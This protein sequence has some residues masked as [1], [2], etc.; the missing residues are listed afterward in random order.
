MKTF[1]SAML[2]AALSFPLTSYGQ[3]QAIP[4]HVDR[5]AAI[6]G[7]TQN[8]SFGMLPV[9]AGN[10]GFYTRLVSSQ[11]VE[12]QVRWISRDGKNSAIF[13]L[14]R[15]PLDAPQTDF[16]VVDFTP[17]PDGGMA[18]LVSL[19]R[20]RVSELFRIIEFNA[21][22][23]YRR[24][25]APRQLS[26]SP[27]RIAA[28]S[29]GDFFLSGGTRDHFGWGSMSQAIVDDSGNI[30]K[31]IDLRLATPTSDAW[32]GPMPIVKAQDS[33]QRE[34]D[35]R[36]AAASSPQAKLFQAA[37]RSAA[38][39]GDDGYVYFTWPIS[40][41]LVY[42]ISDRGNVQTIQLHP[43]QMEGQSERL[44]SIQEDH[45]DLVANSGVVAR[46]VRNGYSVSSYILQVYDAGNGA[47]LA[48]YATREPIGFGLV[49]FQPGRFYFLKK[50]GSAGFAILRSVPE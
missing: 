39:S 28:F 33:K 14:S 30:V 17:L 23:T 43:P 35:P 7:L 24:T 49:Y 37:T 42:R 12:P 40:E 16:N 8:A 4:L 5:S 25:I 26:F 29:A 3:N 45:G 32:A 46:T 48:T 36:V 13:P 21:D 19:Q 50:T 22:G 9:R 1:V 11:G 20:P 47:Q 2:G 34:Q 18:E 44:L 10:G 31:Q 27:N 15:I 41:N 38:L 6:Q